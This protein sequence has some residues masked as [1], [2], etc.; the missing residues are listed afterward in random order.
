M[1]RDK[2]VLGAQSIDFLTQLVDNFYC[3]V[4]NMDNDKLWQTALGDL[5]VS[6]SKAN[7]TTWFKGSFIHEISDNKAIVGVPN[8][9]SKEWLKKKFHPQILETLQ[10]LTNNTV[11]SVEY[12]I[13]T[14]NN[15]KSEVENSPLIHMPVDK[16][17]T[18]VTHKVSHSQHIRLNPKYTF[19]HFIVGGGNR[20]AHAAAEAVADNLGQSYNPLFIYGGVG[21]GKTHLIQAIAHRVLSANPETNIV[22]TSCEQF[23]NNFVESLRK[24]QVNEFKQMYRDVDMLLLDDIQFI[25]GKETTQEE[26]FHTFNALHQQN[27]QII[28]TSDRIPKAIPTLESR[29]SSR[30]EMGL[31]VDINPPDLETRSAIIKSKCVEKSFNL[32]DGM[33]QYIAARITS[34]IREIE[35]AV[36]RLVAHCDL[37]QI[38]PSEDVINE[39]LQ[40]FL[41]GTQQKQ[42]SAGKII[43][44]VAAYYNISVDSLV[45]EKRN[46]EMVM[47]RHIA[48]H[49]LR[50]ELHLSYP[51]IGK[52]F[53]GKDHTTVMH[54]CQKL[55]KELGKDEELQKELTTI[56]ERLYNVS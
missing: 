30:F 8:N 41:T 1:R 22:Y 32:S 33:V 48:M 53:G 47:P 31:I 17:P 27:K 16:S 37:N 55:E 56:K 40:Q 52:E 10:K 42:V 45:G 46:K 15:I 28:I 35:G 26:F 21:L 24:G 4:M 36:N 49:L 18:P 34:N 11:S 14:K 39:C 6:L 44:M 3:G 50:T 38:E 23:T 2:D 7:Y 19:E 5:E 25:A 51:T 20:M 43:K 54:A 9:F 12:I 13:G 29:L